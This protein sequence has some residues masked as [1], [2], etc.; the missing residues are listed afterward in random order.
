MTK[1]LT[2]SE[3]ISRQHDRKYRRLME[4]YSAIKAGRFNH[5]L[6][7]EAKAAWWAD[8]D[9]QLVALINAAVD[10]NPKEFK[11]YPDGRIGLHSYTVVPLKPPTP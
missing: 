2:P 3:K 4:Q 6:D 7:A 9:A 5:L 11:R 10:A 8:L 1:R